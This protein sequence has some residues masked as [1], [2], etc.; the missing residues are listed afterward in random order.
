MSEIELVENQELSVRMPELLDKCKVAE[1]VIKGIRERAYEILEEDPR[2]V[3]GWH[4]KTG[5]TRQVIRDIGGVFQKL[6][7]NHGIDAGKFASNCSIS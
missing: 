4:L 2:A 5:A 1:Q 3:E 7:D 6:K